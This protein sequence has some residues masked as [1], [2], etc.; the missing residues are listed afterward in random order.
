[1]RGMFLGFINRVINPVVYLKTADDI[2]RF[3][4]SSQEF[5]E[6]NEFYKHNFEGIGDYYGRM[7]RR[8][9]AIGF[10][11]D[12]G[13]YK[14]EYRLLHEAA[15]KLAG[16]RDDL[17]VAVVT[18]QTL[19]KAYKVKYG[20]RW[21]DEFSVNTIVLQREPQVFAYYDLEKDS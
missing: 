5:V 14:N 7:G 6:K 20:H 16:K 15:Q 9:R 2:E 11:H 13:E 21:F 18:N 10:F 12:K 3:L 17:R 19:V 4:D 1:M 8:V